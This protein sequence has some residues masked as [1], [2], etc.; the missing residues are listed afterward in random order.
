MGKRNKKK[1][2][3][4]L[5]ELLK[6][7]DD[8]KGYAYAVDGKA[9][10]CSSCR[11]MCKLPPVKIPVK[12]E[13]T[14]TDAPSIGGHHISYSTIYRNFHFACAVRYLLAHP[15]ADVF[16]PKSGDIGDTNGT[17]P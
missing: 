11:K 3:E 16:L 4:Q 1:F 13:A 15:G 9:I 6:D 14:D 5:E 17:N 7:L 8:A 2:L 10:Y 12:I